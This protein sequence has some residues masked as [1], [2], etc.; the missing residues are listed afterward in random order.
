MDKEAT[1]QRAPTF[2]R[3]HASNSSG[4]SPN[5]CVKSKRQPSSRFLILNITT[6]KQ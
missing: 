3:K 5:D 2:C 6:T 4:D 1:S